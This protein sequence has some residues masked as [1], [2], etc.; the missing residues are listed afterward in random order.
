MFFEPRVNV[1][2]SDEGFSVEVLGRTG[3][4][5]TE[6][7][8]VAHIDSELLVGEPA[9]VVYMNRLKTWQAPHENDVLDDAA[10]AK[11][12]ENIRR[13]FRHASHEIDALV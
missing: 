11:I 9:I 4:R 10:K 13:A 7:N 5:Y 1:I 6:G 2:A 3:L 8:R 12:L